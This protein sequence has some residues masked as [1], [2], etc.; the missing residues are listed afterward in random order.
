MLTQITERKDKYLLQCGDMWTRL[1]QREIL[2]LFCK[3]DK[4]KELDFRDFSFC[5]LLVFLK[6][7]LFL[8]RR[9]ISC[10]EWPLPA[11]LGDKYWWFKLGSCAW[12]RQ[13]CIF[14]LQS[15]SVVVLHF[16]L[17]YFYSTSSFQSACLIGQQGTVKNVAVLKK[18]AISLHYLSNG[19]QKWI[20]NL[21]DR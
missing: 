3:M 17:F 1:A 2:M 19:H 14:F 20:E 16:E 9:S 11:F 18:T 10:W 7:L 5:D 4:V 13:V 21:P 15:F 6:K 8:S 12:L